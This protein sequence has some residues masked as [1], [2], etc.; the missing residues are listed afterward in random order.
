MFKFVK[1]N[2]GTRRIIFPSFYELLLLLLV[3]H[4][5]TMYELNGLELSK[6]GSDIVGMYF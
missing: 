1:G 5:T 3:M 2:M 6:I 4:S